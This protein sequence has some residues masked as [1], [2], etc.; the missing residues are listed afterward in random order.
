M[1]AA[2]ALPACGKPAPA[3]GGLFAPVLSYESALPR[4]RP[5]TCIAARTEGAAFDRDREHLRSMRAYRSPNPRDAEAFRQLVAAAENRQFDWRHPA[6]LGERGFEGAPQLDPAQARELDDA[7]RGII[8]AE[9]SQGGP[10]A[11]DLAGIP[12]SLRGVGILRRCST[13]TLTAPV[14]VGDLAFVETSYVCGGLCGNGGLYA[15]RRR[16]GRWR[17]AAIAFTW[18]S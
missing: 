1:A 12:P 3:D 6:P 11:M 15:L 17:L 9:R 7:A 10:S 13:L 4:E 16:D 8:A 5:P 18:V 2:L 14:L